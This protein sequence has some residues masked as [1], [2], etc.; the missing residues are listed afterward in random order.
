MFLLIYC[1]TKHDF[2]D[3]K[4]SCDYKNLVT[5]TVLIVR[6]LVI[7]RGC[8]KNVRD[9]YVRIK[10]QKD[11]HYLRAERKTCFT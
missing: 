9:A 5:C 11:T 3:T 6:N 10:L 8:P 2:L 4:I 1:I 7:P